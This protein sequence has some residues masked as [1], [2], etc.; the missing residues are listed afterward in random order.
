MKKLLSVA[1]FSVLLVSLTGCVGNMLVPT[2][3]T[4][5][6]DEQFK[7][8]V[9]RNATKDEMVAAIGNPD[10]RVALKNGELFE[11]IY[12]TNNGGLKDIVQGKVVLEFNDRDVLVKEYRTGMTW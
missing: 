4:Q 11:Y 6:T 8:Y 10:R 7:P 9:A 2:S 3:G 1:L 12:T 5:W